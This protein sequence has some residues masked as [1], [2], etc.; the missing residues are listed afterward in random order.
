MHSF[1][2]EQVH[3]HGGGVSRRGSQTPSAPRPVQTAY[4]T[5]LFRFRR[6]DRA[7]GVGR[8]RAGLDRLTTGLD[9]VHLGL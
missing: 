5:N 2:C 3:D 7:M 9:A 4:A 6:R 8:I 1:A